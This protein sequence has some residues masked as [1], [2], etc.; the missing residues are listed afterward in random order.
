MLAAMALD[1]KAVKMGSAEDVPA[2][3]FSAAKYGPA[4]FPKVQ[5]AIEGRAVEATM[6]AAALAKD[7]TAAEAKYGVP[8]PAGPEFSVKFTGK[9]GKAD[10]GVYDVAVP[11]MPDN[12]HLSVQTGPAINGTDL[13][14]ATGLIKFGDFNNQIDY[15]NAGS[16]LN[17]EMKKVVLSKIDVSDLTGKTLSVIGAFEP[18]DPAEW[19]ITPVKLTV[20]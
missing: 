16:A 20:Q 6:L 5:S 8:T 12:I 4:Q 9:V 18:S 10:S 19:V 3:E 2:G 7:Q 14:D 13:R 17:N 1:T 15:Q 11:G